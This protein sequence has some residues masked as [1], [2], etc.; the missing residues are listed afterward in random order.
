[1]IIT[2]IYVTVGI[3]RESLEQCGTNRN[4]GGA[5][6]ST[7]A[8]NRQL[9]ATGGAMLDDAHAYPCEMNFFRLINLN[10]ATW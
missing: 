6:S 8:T 5:R 9:V 7:S 2:S 1:M 3:L 4:V 10:L